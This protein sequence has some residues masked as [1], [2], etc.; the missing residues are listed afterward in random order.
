LDNI[1]NCEQIINKMLKDNYYPLLNEQA[2][3]EP[4]KKETKIEISFDLNSE[5]SMKLNKKFVKFNFNKL[6]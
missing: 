3:R 4:S 1:D 6:D 5:S 2:S